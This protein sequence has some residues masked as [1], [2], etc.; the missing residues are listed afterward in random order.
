M[1]KKTKKAFE[2][3][4]KG[5]GL[6]DADVC[7]WLIERDSFLV[8]TELPVVYAEGT[9]LMIK[10]G[11]DLKLK[12]KVWGIQLSSGVILAGNFLGRRS[13][14]KPYS[15]AEIMELAKS[16]T[17]NGKTGSVPQSWYFEKLKLKREWLLYQKTVHTLD[18]YCDSCLPFFWG[19]V[20]TGTN[21]YEENYLRFDLTRVERERGWGAGY[22]NNWYISSAR[23]EQARLAL[24]F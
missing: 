21:H 9:E 4:V 11:L 24:W 20:W 23:F 18:Q 1:D 10:H 2:A 5:L 22:L 8:P 14:G 17:L 19:V 3:V 7:K 12:D 16:Y 15:G 13:D 6:T